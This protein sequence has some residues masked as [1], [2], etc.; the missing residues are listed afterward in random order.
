MY[1]SHVARVLTT[2]NWA[3][4]EMMNVVIAD[5]A[6]KQKRSY[7]LRACNRFKLLYLL[8]TIGACAL[9]AVQ[10]QSL[11]A[12]HRQQVFFRSVTTVNLD[13]LKRPTMNLDTV[14]VR[15]PF[16]AKEAFVQ[17]ITVNYYPEFIPKCKMH[18]ASLSNSVTLMASV[19]HVNGYQPYVGSLV[20]FYMTLENAHSEWKLKTDFRNDALYAALFFNSENFTMYYDRDRNRGH[21]AEVISSFQL[22]TLTSSTTEIPLS[23]LLPC[24]ELQMYVA[25][26]HY[27]LKS[28]TKS[29]CR[30]N[31]PESIKEMR[32]NLFVDRFDAT[33][34]S[35]DPIEKMVA[36][37]R[38]AISG[39]PHLLYDQG[40][41]EKLCDAKYWLPR[42]GCYSNEEGWIYAGKPKNVTV[43]PRVA[44]NCTENA[45]IAAPPTEIS[46]CEC[47]QKCT[48]HKYQMIASE[49]VKHS[50]GN[51]MH[52]KKLKADDL[53]NASA[54]RF[55]ERRSSETTNVRDVCACTFRVCAHTLCTYLS[56][57]SFP[58]F[59][60]SEMLCTDARQ[61]AS[62]PLFGLYYVPIFIAAE[63]T[64]ILVYA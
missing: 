59:P 22:D 39:A 32:S 23:T 43:C 35:Y 15:N 53:P 42:C 4:D 24:E 8:A 11:V 55:T 40:I 19:V 47:F 28:R 37:M 9:Y 5:G 30:N 58:P 57:Q 41:C 64:S 33:Y 6:S 38:D 46:K 16:S 20:L 21:I 54:W 44:N 31:F 25:L 34:L 60:F 13:L 1:K 61:I 14:I 27:T 52:A 36:E 26:Q 12:R 48:S 17:H 7:G 45:K 2:A 62:F 50:F 10:A 56:L 51:T 3:L 18:G 63:R 29:P 49:K